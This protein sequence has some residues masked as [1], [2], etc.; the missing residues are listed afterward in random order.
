MLG[1]DHH[2]YRRDQVVVA[3]H[4]FE[5]VGAFGVEDAEV[6]VEADTLAAALLVRPHAD[7]RLEHEVAHEH[8]AQAGMGFGGLE[9]G[10]ARRGQGHSSGTGWSCGDA[11]LRCWPPSRAIICPVMDGAA[12]M[13]WM[14]A[15]IS[16]TPA[17]CRS[18]TLATWRSNC[19]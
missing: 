15:Q 5:L 3:D 18:G 1:A 2:P 10:R 6:E 14:A 17:L 8:A 4:A 9:F 7:M 13:K 16:C 19:T 11:Q 12:I